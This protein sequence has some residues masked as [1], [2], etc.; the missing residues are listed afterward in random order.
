M[1]CKDCRN[2]MSMHFND[3]RRLYAPPLFSIAGKSSCGIGKCNIKPPYYIRPRCVP[4]CRKRRDCCDK[5]KNY[6]AKNSDISC[7]GIYENQPWFEDPIIKEGWA[8]FVGDIVTPDNIDCRLRPG[9]DDCGLGCN[10]V[11]ALMGPAVCC[12]WDLPDIDEWYLCKI[13]LILSFNRS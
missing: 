2:P 8:D 13:T 3:V 1:S 11:R 4:D 6:W 10:K 12:T 5:F 7:L 9:P